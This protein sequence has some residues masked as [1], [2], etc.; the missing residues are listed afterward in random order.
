[1][2]IAHIILIS[3]SAL[4][5]IFALD[6][7]ITLELNQKEL[8]NSIELRNEAQANTIIQNLDKFIEKRIN[9]VNSISKTDEIQ[10]VI[11][12]SNYKMDKQKNQT[13]DATN[14]L[15]GAIPFLPTNA[16]ELSQN[17]T[18]MI[19]FYKNEYGLDISNNLYVTNQYG[20]FITIDGQTS[21][22][23][24]YTENWW[25]S[26]KNDGIYFGELQHDGNSFTYYIPM[27]LKIVDSKGTF[28]GV[29][30]ASLDLDSLLHDFE[31]DVSLLKTTGKNV[32]LLDKSGKIIYKDGIKYNPS[33]SPIPYYNKLTADNGIVEPDNYTDGLLAVY[34]RSIGYGIFSGFGWMVVLT[35][36]PSAINTEFE[37]N[38]VS[39]ITFSAVG[40]IGSILIGIFASFF[41]AKPIMKLSTITKKLS[42]GDFNIR[43]QKGRLYEIG[44]IVESFNNMA[45]SLKKL[46]ET[47]VKL[48]EANA[49]IKNERLTAIGELA[50]SLAHNMK[51]PLTTIQSSS[52]IL[53]RSYKGDNK[54]ISE[55][56]SRMNRAID[57][58]SQQIDDVLNFVRLT[59][60]NLE[61]TTLIPLVKSVIKTIEIPPNIKIEIPVNDLQINCDARKLEIVFTNIIQNSVQAIG[62]KPDGIIS[63]RWDGNS[64][65]VTIEIEDNGEG[66]PPEILP[67][68]FEPLV[69]TKMQ[70]TGLGLS[71]CRNIIEQHGGT[72]TVKNNPTTFTIKL[73]KTH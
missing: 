31:G 61:V 1:M 5:V 21:N 43:A 59:P 48:A 11:I 32:I 34:S 18:N 29:I 8:R 13:V 45:L 23:V 72:I 46:I 35:Q 69:T 20:A 10:S 41:I 56:A 68:L 28:L 9:D 54:E 55:V 2:K 16:S 30:K 67:K 27:A 66:I 40:I 58:M 17:F 71:T 51:N 33:A 7:Y 22:Y 52:D 26:A 70:G 6:G 4:F 47:E 53:K 64:D 65:M 60:L 49:K 42:E 62:N 44:V 37:S 50:A 25:Q 57:R 39:I 14:E 24:H 15:E 36:D 63:I 19:D 12:L 73:P 3:T 38:A